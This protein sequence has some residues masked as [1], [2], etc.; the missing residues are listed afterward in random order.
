MEPE[1]AAQTP[2]ELGVV[3]LELTAVRG[4]G[5]DVYEIEVGTERMGDAG[6]L[7]A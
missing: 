5:I 3:C 2:V 7:A 1:T 6:L 4:L